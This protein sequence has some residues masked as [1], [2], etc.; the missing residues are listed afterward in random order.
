MVSDTKNENTAL[1]MIDWQCGFAEFATK[2]GGRNNLT[3]ETQA[4]NLLLHWREKQWPIIHIRHD[5]TQADSV[6]RPGNPGNDLLE[7]AKPFGNEPLYVKAVNSCFVGTT[8]EADLRDR[9]IHKL[10]LTGV[11]SDHCLN[12]TARMGANL[13]FEIVIP[14]DATYSF[15]RTD[16][17]GN[18]HSAELVHDIALASLSGEFAT[19]TNTAEILKA[20]LKSSES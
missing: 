15:P 19:I 4:A 18:A 6:F 16:S 3:A 17:Y 8:L 10:V 1:V 7:F 11:S 9:N 2:L 14:E 13:G 12:T 20:E 5:S